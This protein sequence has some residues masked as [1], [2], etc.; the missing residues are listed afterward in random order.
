MELAMIFIAVGLF[1]VAIY[2]IYSG[3]NVRAQLRFL[4]GSLSFEA[5]ERTGGGKLSRRRAQKVLK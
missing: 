4:G 5:S 3:R 1:I 2:A